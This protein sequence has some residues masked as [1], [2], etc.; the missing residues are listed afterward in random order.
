MVHCTYD[1]ETK[2]VP[3]SPAERSRERSTWFLAPY[4]VKAE[5]RLYENIIDEEKGVYNE[6][7]SLNLNPNS[8]RC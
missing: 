1:P 3:A 2:S 4:A 7:G 8:L 6:D 5:V